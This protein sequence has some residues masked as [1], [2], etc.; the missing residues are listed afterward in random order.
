MKLHVTLSKSTRG[1]NRIVM[2]LTV[3]ITF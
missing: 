1:P 2:L 3:S